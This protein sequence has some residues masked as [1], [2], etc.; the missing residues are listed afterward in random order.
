MAKGEEE[1]LGIMRLSGMAR[2]HRPFVDNSLSLR[3]REQVG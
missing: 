2:C 1:G 3:E